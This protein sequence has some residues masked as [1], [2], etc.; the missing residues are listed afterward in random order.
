MY[1][2]APREHRRAA[3]QKIGSGIE[4][5]QTGQTRS[6]AHTHIR[7][8]AHTHIRTYAHTHI[9]TYARRT[10]WLTIRLQRRKLRRRRRTRNKKNRARQSNECAADPLNEVS[11]SK[12]Q[13][14]VRRVCSLTW[15]STRPGVP[16]FQV[17]GATLRMRCR[18][19]LRNSA[20]IF[21][22]HLIAGRATPVRKRKVIQFFIDPFGRSVKIEV[23]V[24]PLFTPE[25]CK[26]SKPAEHVSD[27]FRTSLFGVTAK[28]T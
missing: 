22:D 15:L 7:T 24:Y 8:Y 12:G 14:R 26:F 4:W 20:P 23:L 28:R 6:D 25:R 3:S 5:I 1:Q 16:L 21:D 2:R 19:P 13:P 18:H 17:V 9:R 27:G 11:T 10:I